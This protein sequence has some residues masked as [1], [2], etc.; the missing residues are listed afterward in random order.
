[1][2]HRLTPPLAAFAMACALASIGLPLAAQAAPISTSMQPLT[3]DAAIALALRLNP[4]L[5]AAGQEVAAQQGALT[6]A[7]TRPNPELEL[8]REGSRSD[9][10]TTTA[11]LTIPVELG[12]K[13]AARIDA[14]RQEGQLAALALNAEQARVRADVIAAFHDVVAA[15]AR[16]RMAQELVSLAGRA[17]DAAGKRV[18]AGTLSPVEQTRARVAQGGARIEALQ[19]A[20]ALEAA[21][22]QLAELW[23]GDAR[24]LVVVEPDA[25][26]LPTLP[27]LDRLL[28][29][30]DAAPGMR[31]AG[32]HLKHRQALARLEQARRTPDVNVIVGAQREGPDARNR[33]VL[34]LSVSLP[35]F[36][37]NDGAVLD[38]LRRVDKAQDEQ[39]A[40]AVHLRAELAQA[41]ARLAT[42]LAECA[43]ISTDI[44]PGA[45]DAQ[46]AASRGFELGKFGLV[47][48]L[49]AQ[50]VL[51]QSTYQ[52]LNAVAESHRAQADIA[53][54]LG[55]AAVQENP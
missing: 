32:A 4:T 46:R 22:I 53:R 29:Q 2:K 48:V 31:Q 23:A 43:L 44:L 36:N 15:L 7:G 47:D 17:L 34:G 25:V 11:L 18:D 49:D 10:R 38:A 40:Q 37:R 13:R 39:D 27:P 50:R 26:T 1:M 42:A 6:Q 52:Y 8:L 30:L 21:R 35:L 19:A 45:Q 5:R 33:T 24:G 41:H 20:R 51:A 16:E 54:L 3:L 12:G 9:S 28:A 55:Q 14:A